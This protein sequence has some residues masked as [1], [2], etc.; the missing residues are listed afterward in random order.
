MAQL[1]VNQAQPTLPRPAKELKGLHKVFLKPGEKQ[2]VS[3]PLER[4][5]FAY[6]DPDKKGWVAEKGEFTIMVGS[7]SRDIRLQSKFALSQTLLEN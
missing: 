6:Y 2:K 7:S 1:Y 4:N 5:A 3:I